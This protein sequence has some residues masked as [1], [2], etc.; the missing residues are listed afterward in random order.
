MS[1]S[2]KRFEAHPA[3]LGRKA[4]SIKETASVLGLSV[5]SVRR[6]VARGLLRANRSLRHLL[7][8]ASEID[9]FLQE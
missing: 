9:R 7:I 6:L 3:T 8:P 2:T 5:P 4:F 1:I